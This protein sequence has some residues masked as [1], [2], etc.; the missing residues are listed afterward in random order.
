MDQDLKPHHPCSVA[1]ASGGSDGGC[2][3][4]MG[5]ISSSDIWLLVD[6]VYLA[7]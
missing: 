5:T 7:M 6:C 4:S 1:G 2:K 3:V